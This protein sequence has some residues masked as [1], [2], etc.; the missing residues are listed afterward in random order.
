MSEPMSEIQLHAARLNWIQGELNLVDFPYAP[1]LEAT[2]EFL[3]PLAELGQAVLEEHRTA[4]LA[5]RDLTDPQLQEDAK[6][7]HAYVQE[8]LSNAG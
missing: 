6:A 2:T 3:L 8:L 5:E 4:L 7:A 1:Q